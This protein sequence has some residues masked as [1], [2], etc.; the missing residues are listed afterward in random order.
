MQKTCKNC[1]KDF[2]IEQ[3]DLNFYEKMKSPSPNYCQGC[4]MARRLCFRNERTL[5]KRTCSKS[6]KPI[7][8]IYPE[9][10]LF[11]VYDQ[12]IWWG[13]EWEGL[14]YGQGYDLSRPFFDQWLELR[15]KVPRISMLNI[16]SVNSDYCQ[17][18]EDMKNCYLILCKIP[19]SV[20]NASTAENA[21]NVSF[22]KIARR[23]LTFFSV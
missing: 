3:E 12:H 10:T 4:R 1:K 19:S 17:N 15:N 16:N 2:E 6:G 11:P 22:R 14:D 18:A 23:V 7:I 21:I 20:M 8:S 9:N 13:D 5:Y